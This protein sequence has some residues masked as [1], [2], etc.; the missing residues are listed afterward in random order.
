MRDSGFPLRIISFIASNAFSFSVLNS[1]YG[2]SVIQDFPYAGKQI[3]A[4]ADYMII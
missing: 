2:M 1:G 3:V 4:Q